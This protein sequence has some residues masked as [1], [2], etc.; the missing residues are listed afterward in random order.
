MRGNGPTLKE[1]VRK[2]DGLL[3]SRAGRCVPGVAA[4]HAFVVYSGA[5][6]DAADVLLAGARVI[7]EM[8]PSNLNVDCGRPCSHGKATF[9][10]RG[11]PS[12]GISFAIDHKRNRINYSRYPF[13]K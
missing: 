5:V 7:H 2:E 4:H 13:K 10:T 8:A 11:D 6:G 3:L 12:Q 9:E 1:S